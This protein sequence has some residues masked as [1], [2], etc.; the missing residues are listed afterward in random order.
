M[1]THSHGDCVE[2]GSEDFR[3]NRLSIQDKREGPRPELRDQFFNL[4]ERA[5]IDLRDAF[6]PLFVRQVNNQ[7]I[8]TWSLFRFENFCDRNRIQRISRKSVHGF[9]WKR[10]IFAFAQ[11]FNRMLCSGGLLPPTAIMDRRYSFGFNF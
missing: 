11:Q 10:Y 6:Q 2:P 7:W 4:R 5:S 1:R 9:R 8:E 3:N